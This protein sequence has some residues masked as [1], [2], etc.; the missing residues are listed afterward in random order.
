MSRKTRLL[1]LAGLAVICLVALVMWGG[2][3]RKAST[4]TAPGEESTRQDLVAEPGEIVLYFPG[5]R[6]R[7]YAE[8]R[9][10]AP[11]PVGEE[12]LRL[13][14]EELLAGPENDALSPAL[15][16][17]VT[18]SDITLDEDGTLYLD[19]GSKE[20]ALRGMGSTSELLAVYSLVDT[21]LLNEPRAQR[22]VILWNGRQQ[23]SLAGHVDTARPLALDQRLIAES[24]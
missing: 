13:V 10:L 15:P 1:I 4:M 23:P 6:G 5:S 2:A 22:V 11:G 21:A 9:D 19:L 24:S 7:L 12:R 8:R 16:P 20:G 3:R 18:L 14:I 17:S